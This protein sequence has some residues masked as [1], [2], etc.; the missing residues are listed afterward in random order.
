MDKPEA[1]MTSDKTKTAALRA[2]DEFTNR[3]VN[4]GGLDAELKKALLSDLA[5]D[6]PAELKAFTPAL[7][8]RG[9]K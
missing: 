6:D 1:V 3:I 7:G 5:S 4:D 9:T 2:L 8:A